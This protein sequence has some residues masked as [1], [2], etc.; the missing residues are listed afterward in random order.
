MKIIDFYKKGNVVR[1]YLGEDDLAKWWGDDWNDSPYDYNAGEVYDQY[2]SGYRD[3]AFAFDDMVLEPCDGILN[4]EWC[5]EDM[6]K[7]RVPCIIVVPKEIEDESWYGRDFAHWVGVDGIKK[8]YFGD[9]MEP[10]KME[11]R[12]Q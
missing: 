9:E 4:C 6:I 8:Y 2:V 11:D 1:F 5:K 3:I 12:K 7:R 10:E